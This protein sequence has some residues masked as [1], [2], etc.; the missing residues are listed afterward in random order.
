MKRKFDGETTSKGNEGTPGGTGGQDRMRIQEQI[1]R[2][3]EKT[4]RCLDGTVPPR[5]RPDFY[6]R[7]Q[8]RIRVAEHPER[9]TAAFLFLRRVLIPAGL[10]VMLGFNILTAVLVMRQPDSDAASRQK[11]MAAFAEEYG[12][13]SSAVSSYWK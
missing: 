1:D 4:L 2:E 3:V 11:A 9:P 8:A 6:A 5:P 7:L 10:L 13:E 12:L